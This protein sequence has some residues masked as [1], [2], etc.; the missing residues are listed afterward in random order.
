[1]PTLKSLQSEEAAQRALLYQTNAMFYSLR[2]VPMRRQILLDLE[3]LQRSAWLTLRHSE[4]HALRAV[5]HM[6]RECVHRD[7]LLQQ[8][9]FERELL[10]EPQFIAF[11]EMTRRD[12]V[13]EEW[14]HRKFLFDFAIE[15]RIMLHGE[16]WLFEDPDELAGLH[17]SRQRYSDAPN[18][19]QIGSHEAKTKQQLLSPAT[20]DSIFVPSVP[21]PQRRGWTPGA[22]GA[23]SQGTSDK[24]NTDRFAPAARPSTARI[25]RHR[26]TLVDQPKKNGGMSPENRPP[27]QDRP[28]SARP[29]V[30]QRPSSSSG[31]RPSSLVLLRHAT[32]RPHGENHREQPYFTTHYCSPSPPAST[33][34]SR[35][36]SASRHQRRLNHGSPLLM[37]TGKHASISQ[38]KELL[39]QMPLEEVER[40]VPMIRLP[41]LDLSYRANP[42][43]VAEREARRL[44]TGSPTSPSGGRDILTAAPCD[45]HREHH[46]VLRDGPP[47]ALLSYSSPFP[48]SSMVTLP[49]ESL[50]ATLYALQADQLTRAPDHIM[51]FLRGQ[52]ALS[53][54][55]ASA[56][57][58]DSNAARRPACP[59]CAVEYAN[60]QASGQANCHE[61][62]LTVSPPSRPTATATNVGF[63][64]PRPTVPA[65]SR[66]NSTAARVALDFTQKGE[67]S[68][69]REHSAIGPISPLQ[70]RRTYSLREQLVSE[71][72]FLRELDVDR[73]LCH[74]PLE[75]LDPQRDRE[76]SSLLRQW[77]E[78]LHA[79]AP[80]VSAG[81][82]LSGSMSL[83]AA[84]ASLTAASVSSS[85]SRTPPTLN[86]HNQASASTTTTN[87][88]SQFSGQ[89]TRTDLEV[90]LRVHCQRMAREY[91]K[92][93]ILD[94]FPFVPAVVDGVPMEE[95]PL[96][97]D[98]EFSRLASAFAAS[99]SAGRVPTI[100]HEHRV[101]VG[102]TMINARERFFSHLETQSRA[103]QERVLRSCCPQLYLEPPAQMWP[104]P[105]E[106]GCVRSDWSAFRSCF[107]LYASPAHTLGLWSNKEFHEQ[108]LRTWLP[109]TVESTKNNAADQLKLF[110]IVL[111]AARKKRM[112]IFAEA[113]LQTRHLSWS[114]DELEVYWHASMGPEIPKPAECLSNIRRAVKSS[115]SNTTM[116]LDSI[117][118]FQH[119]IFVDWIPVLA[120]RPTSPPRHAASNAPSLAERYLHQATRDIVDTAYTSWWTDEQQVVGNTMTW[121][122]YIAALPFLDFF[123]D[124]TFMNAFAAWMVLHQEGGKLHDNKADLLSLQQKICRRAYVL[125]NFWCVHEKEAL[126][127]Q[128]RA[129]IAAEERWT[130][131]AERVMSATLYN[132]RILHLK[133]EEPI[134]RHCVV[135]AFM[136]RRAEML[137]DLSKGASVWLLETHLQYK[138]RLFFQSVA[139]CRHS[140]YERNFVSP[141]MDRLHAIA[142]SLHRIARTHRNDVIAL[143]DLEDSHRDALANAES[144]M[145]SAIMCRSKEEHL[146]AHRAYVQRLQRIDPLLTLEREQRR[147]VVAA[148]VAAHESLFNT[149]RA[150]L[151]AALVLQRSASILFHEE[152]QTRERLTRLLLRELAAASDAAEDVRM[153]AVMKERRRSSINFHIAQAQAS[154]GDSALALRRPG[155]YRKRQELEGSAIPTTNGSDELQDSQA[156]SVSLQIISRLESIGELELHQ[157]GTIMAEEVT[158]WRQV[159]DRVSAHRRAVEQR[160]RDQQLLAQSAPFHQIFGMP[161]LTDH[162]EAQLDAAV[163]AAL[164]VESLDMTMSSESQDVR[165]RYYAAT[166]SNAVDF[167][168]S[169][170]AEKRGVLSSQGSLVSP[171]QPQPI[172]RKPSTTPSV[173]RKR[174][175]IVHHGHK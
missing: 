94:L 90:R 47:V 66:G 95:L 147:E 155:S 27:W 139:M 30:A 65:R 173:E 116:L 17:H 2:A 126:E 134:H 55:A 92:R 81:S 56:V 148:E 18:Q 54:S 9:F 31:K 19:M 26:D 42:T 79:A 48:N 63:V 45:R 73:D 157:R 153:R 68:L 145:R 169:T 82:G 89:S 43:V 38:T 150:Q 109:A 57:G 96:L 62:A 64:T 160:L 114:A 162:D 32:N 107:A 12:L 40:L 113:G 106:A 97:E 58:D 136:V 125:A 104:G 115:S 52:F 119:L 15:A 80:A 138:E 128:K 44:F 158:S 110:E 76:F 142:A 37:L 16:E 13:R 8:F 170:A 35:P 41:R 167:P 127:A 146:L 85:H 11:E 120:Q 130:A 152:E 91:Q 75:V 77:K 34:P 135:H 46:S 165:Q 129:L 101:Q 105:K 21:P 61:P 83:S 117:A 156:G 131:N 28:S 112:S 123:S 141:A 100:K 1:M 99:E 53:G 108:L 172:L 78:S 59:W 7:E 166:K 74:V 154:R 159:L 140:D 98:A 164:R 144:S 36:I 29:A 60:G 171:P 4:L 71:F 118:R 70:A 111:S 5:L 87:H 14:N 132:K 39:R 102:S 124:A 50:V 163:N 10:L 25:Y 122:Q 3:Q 175:R 88:H 49:L 151:S 20:L 168:S 103:Y 69:P 137:Y 174:V 33:T 133:A 23:S 24:I 72:P 84:S 51:S 67:D 86:N 143:T 6:S 121:D 149:I 22:E 93:R 161:D